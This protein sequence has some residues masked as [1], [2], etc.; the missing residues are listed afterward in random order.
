MSEITGDR[1]RIVER[2]GL[3]LRSLLHKSDP[4]DGQKCSDPKCL[5]C[6]NPYNK[7]FGCSKRNIVYK[8][9][10]LTCKA[11]TENNEKADKKKD[12]IEKAYFGE[13]H[14]SGLERS[15]QHRN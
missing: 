2:A 1:L 4:W 15:K 14:V 5:I 7:K 10:C 13:S 12:A 9:V 11:E 8:S 3:K 6:T